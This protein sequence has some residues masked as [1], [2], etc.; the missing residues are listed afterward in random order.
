MLALSLG[1]GADWALIVGAVPVTVGGVYAL[2]KWFMR[3][4]ISAI[5]QELKARNGGGSLM[6]ATDQIKQAVKNVDAKLDEHLSYH[7]GL[8]DAG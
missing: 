4:L 2:G 1:Q 3:T 7:Q 8:R 6:D 5:A